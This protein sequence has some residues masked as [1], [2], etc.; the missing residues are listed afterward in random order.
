V[1]DTASG[2]NRV[3]KL[4][5]WFG[6]DIVAQ[7]PGPKWWPQEDGQRSTGR[8]LARDGPTPSNVGVAS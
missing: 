6:A 2:N 5:R 4:A 1:G 3:E 8:S 7:R